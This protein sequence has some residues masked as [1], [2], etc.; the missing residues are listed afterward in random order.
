MNDQKTL[1]FAITTVQELRAAFRTYEHEIQHV[2]HPRAFVRCFDAET[3][4]RLKATWRPCNRFTS[5]EDILRATTTD[6]L[7]RREDR[8]PAA[9][10]STTSPGLASVLERLEEDLWTMTQQAHADYAEQGETLIKMAVRR[11]IAAHDAAVSRVDHDAPHYQS[12][13]NPFTQKLVREADEPDPFGAAEWTPP[14][15]A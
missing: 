6:V 1:S 4:H 10:G 2:R 14:D 9:S 12:I 13:V 15:P 5:F 7:A 8:A 3:V 11:C